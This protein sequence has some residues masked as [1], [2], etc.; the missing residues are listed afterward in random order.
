MWN[1]S[2]LQNTQT[3]MFCN[4]L[5]PFHN[6]TLQCPC[7][8]W[9]LCKEGQLRD[10]FY[11][12]APGSLSSTHANVKQSSITCN[13]CKKQF[14][15]TSALNPRQVVALRVCFKLVKSV[16]SEDI[17]HV[18]IWKATWTVH[19]VGYSLKMWRRSVNVD[20]ETT[21][22]LILEQM[23]CNLTHMTVVQHQDLRFDQH[24]IVEIQM[25]MMRRIWSPGPKGRLYM[26]E[27]PSNRDSGHQSRLKK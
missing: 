25:E 6:L 24:I 8:R 18:R 22:K 7:N 14:L 11:R 13:S 5:T 10:R 16:T 1:L 2:D 9:N 21:D 4:G 20:W 3:C 15:R 26:E 19:I 17:W 27:L 23:S 12:L